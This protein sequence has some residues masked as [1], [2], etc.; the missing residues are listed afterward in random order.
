MAISIN[1]QKVLNLK[2]YNIQD[3]KDATSI[4]VSA[5]EKCKKRGDHKNLFFQK[6]FI[7]FIPLL[8][9]KFFVK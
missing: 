9:L 1:A 2:D 6:G 5:L 7:I 4:V 8:H 3:A